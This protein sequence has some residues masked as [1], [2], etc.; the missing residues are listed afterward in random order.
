MAELY[1]SGSSSSI[2]AA[3]VIFH[4]LRAVDSLPEGYSKDTADVFFVEKETKERLP[5]HREVLKVGSTVFFNMFDGDWKEKDKN[6]IPAPEEYIWESFKAAITLLYGEEV[7]VEESSVPDIYRVAHLYDLREVISVLVHEICQWDSDMVNTVVELCVLTQDMLD[8]KNSVLNAS[9]QYIASHLE[10][11][12]P[13]LISQLSYET[14][15]NLVKS[16]QVTS[17]ELVLLRLLHQWANAH[18]TSTLYEIQ[19]LYSHIRFGTIPYE[20]LAECS[21]IGHDNLKSALENHQELSVDCVRRN[22]VQ[23]TPR[24]AQQEV[25][26]AY[27]MVRGIKPMVLQNGQIEI[28]NLTEQH[29]VG[30]I[31]CGRQEIKFQ[32]E[33]YKEVG[34]SF[35]DFCLCRLFSL[36]DDSTRAAEAKMVPRIDTNQMCINFTR[37]TV[38]LDQTGAHFVLTNRDLKPRD[39]NL[40]DYDLSVNMNVD[41]PFTGHFPWVLTLGMRSKAQ[42][43]S[44][45]AKRSTLTFHPPTI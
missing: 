17:E 10:A 42:W 41:L 29:T 21:M 18:L 2:S 14:M 44:P 8:T 27:P 1:A 13:L 9:L 20:S 31:Y 19:Q 4:P 45:A 32:L 28:V 36:H 24:M 34:L 12:S 37:S 6:E 11:V 35:D 23:V 26:Q 40:T 3:T 39:S 7:E 16:E 33:M 30:I 5:A 25:F 15:L 22:L 38:V 43:S